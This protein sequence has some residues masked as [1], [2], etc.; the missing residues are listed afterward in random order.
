MKRVLAVITLVL[1]LL[2][3]MALPVMAEELPPPN[4]LFS[5]TLSE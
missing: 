1:T 5:N 3:L 2:L 4:V